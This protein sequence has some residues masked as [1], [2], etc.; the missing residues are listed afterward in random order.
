MTLKTRIGRLE[1]RRPPSVDAI[2]AKSELIKRIDALAERMQAPVE[3]GAG[4]RALDYLALRFG[5]GR[6]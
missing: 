5:E 3:Q 1:G 2:G 4:Q 6:E